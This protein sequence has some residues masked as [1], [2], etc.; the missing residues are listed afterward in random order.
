MKLHGMKYNGLNHGYEVT[1]ISPDINNLKALCATDE[2]GGDNQASIENG[3]IFE[4]T[5]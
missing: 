1:F 4:V 5:L 2:G 3:T